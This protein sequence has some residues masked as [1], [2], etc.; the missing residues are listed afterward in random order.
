MCPDTGESL[1]EAVYPASTTGAGDLE[2]DSGETRS[3][4]RDTQDN[5]SK[6]DKEKG[7]KVVL[8]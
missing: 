4:D 3:G 2:L 1:S 5:S 7:G 6:P 8:S